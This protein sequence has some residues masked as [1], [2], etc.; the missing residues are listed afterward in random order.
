[1]SE[2]HKH[3]VSTPGEFDQ[4]SGEERIVAIAAILAMAVIRRKTQNCQFG[5]LEES[6]PVSREGLAMS[7]EQVHSFMATRPETK[8]RSCT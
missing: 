4:L 6:L 7:G 2:Y 3:R 8:I 1:M 5:I